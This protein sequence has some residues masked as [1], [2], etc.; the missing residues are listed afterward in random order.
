MNTAHLT[1][2][3]QDLSSF[4]RCGDFT[5]QHLGQRRGQAAQDDAPGGTR[6]P[7]D[8][9]ARIKADVGQ[10]IEG[11]SIHKPPLTIHVSGMAGSPLRVAVKTPD[12]SFVVRSDLCLAPRSGDGRGQHL[13]REVILQ[14]LKAVNDTEYS[15][16]LLDLED[17]SDDL[18]VPFKELTALKKKILFALNGSRRTTDPV[19]APP[20]PDP[21][22]AVIRPTLSVLVSSAEDL[23]VCAELGVEA[24]LQLPSS[25][26]DQR[27]QIEQLL[28]SHRSITPWFPSVLI[29][30]E[31][32]AAVELLQRVR[33]R[34]IVTNN[35]GIA[36][37]AHEA[38]IP[39][40]AGPYLNIANSL[41]LMCLS[42][43]FACQGAFISNELSKQQIR[44]IQAPADFRLYFSI[45][46]PINLLTSRQCLFHQVTGCHKSRLDDACIRECDKA[47][48]IT[49]LKQNTY[50]I[51]KTRG[52]PCALYNEVNFLN[53]DILT[54]LPNRFTSLLID[55]RRIQTRTAI[56]MDMAGV[57][58]LFED[59]LRD[60]RGT[61]QDLREAIH[62]TTDAQYRK[63]I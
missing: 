38:G 20:L 14:R 44:R 5:A 61:A 39:W 16:E 42:E 50:F 57:I 21:T 19:E 30:Q 51:S 62:P 48:S 23:K 28:A 40:V 53:T 31:Y 54:D 3:P 35:T 7:Y 60:P 9:I 24:H 45:Y 12:T 8:E 15:L 52:D 49:D 34:R 41:S 4:I 43:T 18:Y 1:R 36:Y 59:H 63:G 10:I 2:K 55:L 6:A 46:H 17:L 25:Q 47:A 13:N 33:P 26:G 56:T 32:R 29:G 22:L 37:Q 11:L 27:S 58:K